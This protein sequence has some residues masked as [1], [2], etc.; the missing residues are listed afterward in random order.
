MWQRVTVSQ[1]K[2]DVDVCSSAQLRQTQNGHVEV[3]AA[4]KAAWSPQVLCIA[5]A[6]C[7]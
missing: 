1:E 4:Y 2:A 5:L 6:V 3:V 7:L